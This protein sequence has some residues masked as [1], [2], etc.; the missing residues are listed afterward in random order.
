MITD[1]EHSGQQ[2]E[3]SR[4]GFRGKRVWDWLALLIVP[5][6]LV[7]FGLWFTGQQD[8]R[9][10][11][12]ENQRAEAERE[13]AEQRAQ[14][15][16]LQTYLDQMSRLLLESDLRESEVDS[17]VRTLARARTLTVLSRLDP[18]RKTAVMHFLGEA[19]LI[20]RVEGRG[21]IINLSGAELSYADLRGADLSGAYVYQ[22]DLSEAE[23]ISNEKLEQQAASLEG[24]TMPNGQKY[25]D[26]LKD[27]ER[28]EDE[29]ENE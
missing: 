26:W 24:A 14:D 21:P 9:R 27:R 17:E 19:A 1:R 11:Q 7:G 8:Q 13:L 4:W 12:I 25:E 5:F 20:R 10:Q 28:R 22:A 3:Q 6:A 23:G 2:T 18:S 16:A 29:G 15:E